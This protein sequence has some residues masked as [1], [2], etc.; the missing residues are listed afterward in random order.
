MVT[1]VKTQDFYPC[2]LQECSLDISITGPIAE[3]VFE[4][5]YENNLDKPIECTY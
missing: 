4:Q 5:I 3:I 1:G 2:P